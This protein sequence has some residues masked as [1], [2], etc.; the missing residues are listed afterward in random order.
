M[1]MKKYRLD[2]ENPPS[3]SEDQAKQDPRINPW[4]WYVDDLESDDENDTSISEQ[5]IE[6]E[7]SA[8]VTSHSRR[9]A[10]VDPIK[11][12]EVCG[13]ILPRLDILTTFFVD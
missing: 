2:N 10:A 8:Y 4:Q 13:I 9:S 3:D 11:F 7:Y 1:Q 5:T 12:W 6:E